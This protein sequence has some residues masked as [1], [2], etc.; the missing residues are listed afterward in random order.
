MVVLAFPGVS[1]KPLPPGVLSPQR[2]GL[3][4][5][6]LKAEN[7]HKMQI[8]LPH[9]KWAGRGCR[10]EGDGRGQFV[11]GISPTLQL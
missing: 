1:P 3:L 7:T 6:C 5:L 4:N 8:L 2:I 11:W 10:R 9:L